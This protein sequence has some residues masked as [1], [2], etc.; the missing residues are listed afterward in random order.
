M[1]SVLRG[2]RVDLTISYNPESFGAAERGVGLVKT[3]MKKMEEEGTCFKEALEVFRNT[4]NM[5]GYSPNQLTTEHSYDKIISSCNQP[6]LN[7]LNHRC[8]V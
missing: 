4:R 6:Q 3:I 8:M 7:P 1:E 5:R 2:L